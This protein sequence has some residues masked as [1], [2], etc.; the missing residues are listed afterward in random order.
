MIFKK[1][2]SYTQMAL[3]QAHIIMEGQR[4]AGGGGE[5]PG[6]RLPVAFFAVMFDLQ[7]LKT[8]LKEANWFYDDVTVHQRSLVDNEP[9]FGWSSDEKGYWNQVVNKLGSKTRGDPYRYIDG[10]PYPAGG[11]QLCCTSQPWKGMILASRLMPSLQEAWNPVA[12]QRLADYA[13]RWVQIGAWA[14]WGNQTLS[15]FASAEP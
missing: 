6:H 14:V 11:Y 2:V 10:G 5:V 8:F 12:W 1:I 9:I 4:F 13:D 15:A 3:D 7:E